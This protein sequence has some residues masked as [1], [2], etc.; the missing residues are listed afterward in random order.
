MIYQNHWWLI[1]SPASFCFS[2]SKYWGR[3][4]WKGLCSY[5]STEYHQMD[6]SIHVTW[7][8]KKTSYPYNGCPSLS[9]SS[10]WQLFSWAFQ[11]AQRVQVLLF[12]VLHNVKYSKKTLKWLCEESKVNDWGRTALILSFFSIN[13][14]AKIL[15]QECWSKR[16]DECQIMPFHVWNMQNCFPL[17]DDSSIL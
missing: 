16:M 11:E 9:S 17:L 13:T 15:R 6:I 1:I 5:S 12:C 8:F 2:E 14:C 3:K 7:S 10:V 4:V